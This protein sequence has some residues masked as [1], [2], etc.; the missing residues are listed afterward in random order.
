MYSGVTPMADELSPEQLAEYDAESVR[1][2]NEQLTVL[3]EILTGY[4][5]LKAEAATAKKRSE[6]EQDKLNA[7]IR[8]R[9]EGRGKGPEKTLLD[10]AKPAKWR[11]QWTD[12]LDI[13]LDLSSKLM[14]SGLA[15]AGEV[16]D[17]FSTIDPTADGTPLGLPLA[18]VAAIRE[19]VQRLI[20]KE[21]VEAEAAKPAAPDDLW[22]EHPISRWEK[23]GL[24]PKDVDS[25]AAGELKKEDAR[26]PIMTVGD[27]SRFSAP[28][29][30]GW[31]R[32]LTDIKGIGPG[33][34]E[35]IHNA[36]TAFWAWWQAGGDATFAA[37]RGLGGNGNA[38]E[39]GPGSGN[40]ETPASAAE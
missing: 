34:A 16:Y 1:L 2:I 32:K 4:E 17:Q 5:S 23:F 3:D 15:T 13:P 8:E 39:P 27:L 40:P 29:G 9:R 37:E 22:R 19:A 28:S 38:T 31:T 30:S 10:F 36:E 12:S 7:M 33:G 25:L 14:D 35:R 24:K 18:D 11:Q 20:D 21:A 6:A 26:F